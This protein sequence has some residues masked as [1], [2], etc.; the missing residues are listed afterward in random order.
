MSNG[1]YPIADHG[2]R[3]S[4]IDIA[5]N[6][7][8]YDYNLANKPIQIR[9]KPEK[10]MHIVNTGSSVMAEI[11][12]ISGKKSKAMLATS[13]VFWLPKTFELFSFQYFNF[14]CTWWKLFRKR[15]E[16]TKLDIFPLIQ[17]LTHEKHV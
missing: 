1:N 16:R 4:P 13:L 8:E 5:T 9:Y 11:K 2:K 10:Q 3:Q 15:A 7:V 17:N 6:T 12:E 14:E